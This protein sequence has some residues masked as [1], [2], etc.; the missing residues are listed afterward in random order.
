MEEN[1]INIKEVAKGFIRT[2]ECDKNS[3][4][5]INELLSLFAKVAEANCLRLGEPAEKTEEKNLR[6][7]VLNYDIDIVRMPKRGDKFIL[8]SWPSDEVSLYAVRDFRLLGENKEVM[9]NASS[10]WIMMDIVRRRPVAFTKVSQSLPLFR[11]RAKKTD[12]PKLSLPDEAEFITEIKPH[13]LEFDANFHVNNVVYASW[14]YDSLPAEFTENKVL[15]G[16]NIQYK[17]GIMFGQNVRAEVGNLSDNQ[18]FH[19]FTVAET[20]DVAA[21]IIAK[22]KENNS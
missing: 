7:V 11:E 9:V 14:I 3:Y 2:S 18:T 22:W 20:G 21:E 1:D 13:Y 6:W 5:K 4:L 10:R 16:V 8:E 19:R 15:C 12:F 17:K